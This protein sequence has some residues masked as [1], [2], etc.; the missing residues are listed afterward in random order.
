VAGLV[1]HS[2]LVDDLGHFITRRQ[3]IGHRPQPEACRKIATAPVQL[4]QQG[5]GDKVK[6]WR[7][8]QQRLCLPLKRRQTGP[9]DQGDYLGS[10]RRLRIDLSREVD[11][12]FDGLAG[13]GLDLAQVYLGQRMGEVEQEHI[14]VPFFTQ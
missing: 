6:R 10:E 13:R 11:G 8:D 5:H 12:A 2:L 14:L 1:A 3:A 9:I 7:I 4:R